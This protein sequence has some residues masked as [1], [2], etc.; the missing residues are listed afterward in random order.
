MECT[1]K[2]C[3][4]GVKNLTC[5]KCNKALVPDTIIG[6][7]NNKVNVAKCPAGCGQIKSPM[8]CGDDMVCNL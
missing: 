4:M 7:N 6:A 3:G 5:S 8:C 2:K 1:C